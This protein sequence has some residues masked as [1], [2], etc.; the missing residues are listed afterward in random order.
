MGEVAAFLKR[1]RA[2]QTVT[3]RQARLIFALDAT[4]SREPTWQRAR[5]LH[6]ALFDAAASE[7]SLSVQLCYYRGDAEF[8]ASDW[9]SAPAAL[10]DQ[11]SGVTCSAGLTQISRLLSHAVDAGSTNQPVRALVFV[12]DACEEPVDVL[13]SLAGQCRLRQLP[14]FIFQEGC[15]EHARAIFKKMAIVSGGAT[16]PLD[17]DSA[18]RLRELLKAVSRFARGGIKALQ[19]SRTPE[20][21]LLLEQLQNA[22]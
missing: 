20:D 7:A 18:K 11:M 6:G 14:L 10:L 3:R 4:A 12:G 5:A 16:I 8:H 1:T 2:I 19:E 22:P 13:L 17:I 21:K 15:D 9:F